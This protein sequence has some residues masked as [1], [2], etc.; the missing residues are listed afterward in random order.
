M[1]RRSSLWNVWPLWW[2]CVSQCFSRCRCEICRQQLPQCNWTEPA[3][4]PKQIMDN[5]IC[6]RVDK[7]SMRW[8]SNSSYLVPLSVKESLR[9][10]DDVWQWCSQCR[11]E[12]FGSVDPGKV[13][14]FLAH[15]EVLEAL[16]VKIKAVLW[17]QL[18][19]QVVDDAVVVFWAVEYHGLKEMRKVM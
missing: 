8:K 18:V 4:S 19:G 17:F 10:N 1:L 13:W 15:L 9:E 5:K 16:V 3:L 12:S 6:A 2:I 7:K 14:E 11:L